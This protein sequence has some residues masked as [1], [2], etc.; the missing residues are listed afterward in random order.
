M[1]GSGY[2]PWVVLHIPHDATL[3]PEPVRPQFLFAD[4]DHLAFNLTQSSS[5]SLQG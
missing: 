1:T 5:G 4:Q 3:I 2:P